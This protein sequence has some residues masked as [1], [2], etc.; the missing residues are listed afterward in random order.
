MEG[1]PIHLVDGVKTFDNNTYVYIEI[2]KIAAFT[3]ENE[4][5]GLRFTLAF[6]A[7]FQ[8]NYSEREVLFFGRNMFGKL[9]AILGPSSVHLVI[10]CR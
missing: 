3:S 5:S 7:R 8:E 9:V 4:D 6:W 1:I 2:D 10:V